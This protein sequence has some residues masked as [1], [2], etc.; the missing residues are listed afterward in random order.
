MIEGAS[1]YRITRL[2]QRGGMAEVF[3][4][5]ILGE[6]GFSRQV[7]IKRLLPT[8]AGDPDFVKAFVGEAKLVSQL[9]HANLVSV[10]DFGTMD[11]LPFQVLELVNGLDLER[12]DAHAKEYGKALPA[13]AW[14]A[15]VSEAAHGLDYAHHARDGQGRPLGIVH[16]DVSP[17]NILTGWQGGVKIGDFGIAH[18]LADREATRIGVVKGKLAFMAPEQIQGDGV[19]AR[20]D[21]FALGCVL[22]R[23]IAGKSPLETEEERA[24]FVSGAKV[25]IDPS[26]PI[27]IVRILQKA[28]EPDRNRRYVGAAHLA[29]DCARAATARG[30]ADA[31]A[32]IRDWM[33]RL[34]PTEERPRDLDP[35]GLGQ[36]MN[37]EVVLAPGTGEEAV[38]R[39]ASQVRKAPDHDTRAGSP[40]RGPTVG[41]TPAKTI[42]S[43]HKSSSNAHDPLI[44]TV[45]GEYQ[46][47]EMIGKGG[48][49]RV[50]R[51]KHLVFQS[52]FALKVL[53]ENYKESPGAQRRF[54]REALAL[55]AVSHPNLVTIE[56]SGVT[57]DGRPYI[58]M[59]MVHG[60]T[61]REA[62]MQAG[63]P[64]GLHRTRRLARQIGLA[65]GEA[66]K[67]GFV[68]R[69]L[70]PKN[71]VLMPTASGEEAKV[72]DFGLAL[73]LDPRSEL[74]RLTSAGHYLGTA[75]WMAPEQVV[76]AAKVGPAADL[77]CLGLIIYAMSVGQP[78][79]KGTPDEVM[80][81]H[82]EEIP[83]IPAVA[84]PFEPLIRE[85]LEKDPALRPPSAMSVVERLDRLDL[86]GATEAMQQEPTRVETQAT[87]LGALPTRLTNDPQN[88]TVPLM[89][90][91]GESIPDVPPNLAVAPSQGGLKPGLVAFAVAALLVAAGGGFLLAVWMQNDAVP[92]VSA[93]AMPEPVASPEPVAHAAPGVIVQPSPTPTP[94]AEVT[95]PPGRAPEID[96]ARA[97]RIELESTNKTWDQRVASA[98]EK[99]GLSK[100]EL[101]LTPAAKSARASWAAAREGRDAKLIEKTASA[102]L[103]E[104]QA[105]EIDQKVLQAKLESVRASLAKAAEGQPT[106]VIDPLEKRYLNAR[107]A[108]TSGKSG[109]ELVRELRELERDIKK[110]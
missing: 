101:D 48:F 68:H 25:T 43:A 67:Q 74:T 20:T 51:A 84:G 46:V 2:I 41:R 50:Y 90:R 33:E 6:G 79:F 13:E 5:N 28:L 64:F 73:L 70:K 7:A 71:I 102:L 80:R 32:I 72:L 52:E 8:F 69:D 62:L 27:D 11:G 104:I 107:S 54:Q 4:A 89:S 58:V 60:P 82:R 86:G 78:P 29:A 19:D 18:S 97:A 99:K 26:V 15:I 34:R 98:L 24:R 16:R 93:P 23:L 35:L 77:Y 110:L 42:E 76:N 61:L 37:V 81:K 49:A 3:E 53:L 44:N 96:P 85:L 106:A 55:H 109:A 45:I 65:L 87:E 83:D 31:R 75:R 36:L 57:P 108:L 95:E 92:R 103:A 38:R 91:P 12:L 40:Q 66:H 59:E 94:V 39:F 14:L 22:H 9:Q 17:S 1:R 63:G 21:V 105:F 100:A 47:L 88:L 30:N 56:D 10:F